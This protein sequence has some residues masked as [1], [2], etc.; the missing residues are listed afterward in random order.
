MEVNNDMDEGTIMANVKNGL[1]DADGNTVRKA[2]VAI[3]KKEV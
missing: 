3:S 2:V 1:K